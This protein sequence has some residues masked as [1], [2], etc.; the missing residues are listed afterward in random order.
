MIEEFQLKKI[1]N[2]KALRGS[3]ILNT[4]NPPS[5]SVNIESSVNNQTNVFVT[6][7]YSFQG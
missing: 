3:E 6:S 1:F 4:V 7:S 2:G 5:L